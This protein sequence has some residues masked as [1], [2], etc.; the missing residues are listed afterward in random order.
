MSEIKKSLFKGT[1]YIAVS[2]YSGLVVSLIITSVLARKLT[3]DEFGVIAI[4][5]VFISLFSLFADMGIGPAI[6]QYK[7]LTKKDISSLY[8]LSVWLGLFLAVGFYFSSFAVAIYYNNLSLI[9]ICKIL[10]IQVFFATLNVVP[11]SLL[12]KEEKFNII[13]FRTLFI[14][15]LCGILSIFAVYNGWGIYALLIAPVLGAVFTYFVNILYSKLK[16]SLYLD[17]KV[18]KKVYSFSVFQFMF[19]IIGYFGNNLHSLLIG[20]YINMSSL[21]YYEK[22]TRLI[23]LPVQNIGGVITPVLHPILSNLQGDASRMLSIFI[24]F[25]QLFLILSVLIFVLFYFSADE[26]I[27]LLFGKQW[28]AAIS[29]VKIIS[30][31]IIP[32][33]TSV[34]ICAVFQ[35]LGKTKQLF[36]LGN[37]NVFISISALIVS[38]IINPTIESI[39]WGCVISAVLSAIISFVFVFK[40]GFGID[41][42]RYLAFIV[43]PVLLCI[44]L[45]IFMFVIQLLSINNVL[46]SFVVNLTIIFVTGFM[47]F[48]LFY[49]Y[50]PLYYLSILLNKLKK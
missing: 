33:I 1:F 42:L 36:H 48:Q 8:G 6:I 4:A 43:K 39:C 2:K 23:A 19:N 32:R 18:L 40:Y 37:I 34:T 28:I 25:T 17:I 27:L 46:T 44:L 30:F 22:T 50:K 3:P 12:L 31:T 35:S 21:G 29:C 47:Y 15:I 9:N 5:S 38:L 20:R 24:K 26:L 7:D 41:G 14:Q 10:S 16:V 49:E 11:N 45:M 13:A